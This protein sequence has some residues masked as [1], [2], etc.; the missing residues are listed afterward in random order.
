[1]MKPEVSGMATTAE[2]LQEIM[3][4]RDLKQVDIVRMAQPFCKEY[5]LKL[6]QSDMSQFV[7]GKVVPGQWKITLISKALDVSEA[8]LMGYDVPME[9]PHLKIPGNSQGTDEYLV[10]NLTVMSDTQIRLVREFLELPESQAQRVLDFLAGLK[11][12]GQA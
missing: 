5:N 10:E 3:K 8:W 2:R 1:M 12:A 4:M 6:S 9:R 7:S 11:S